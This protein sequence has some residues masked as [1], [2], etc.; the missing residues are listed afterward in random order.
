MFSKEACDIPGLIQCYGTQ[1][2]IYRRIGNLQEAQQFHLLEQA[3]AEKVHD[4]P[5]LARSLVNQGEILWAMGDPLKAKIALE[6]AQEIARRLRLV[7]ELVGSL[8]NEGL[9]L[10][11]ESGGRNLPQKQFEEAERIAGQAGLQALAAHVRKL[12]QK[13]SEGDFS[14]RP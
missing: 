9:L 3:L 8:V 2:S 6:K 4:G 14:R 13:L 10:F 12:R 5:A 1:A 7:P 11:A